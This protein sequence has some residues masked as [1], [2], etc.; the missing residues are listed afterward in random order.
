MSSDRCKLDIVVERYDLDEFE[1]LYD[2]VD[3]RLLSRWTGED[4]KSS[5]GYRALTEWFNKRLLKTVYDE[6]GRDTTGTRVESDYAVLT[7]DKELL[8]E[9]VKDELRASGINPEQV[10][11]DMISWSTMRRHLNSCLDGEKQVGGA[12]S[13][14][15]QRSVD[16]ASKVAES[17][18]KEALSSL[19]SAG[20][21]PAGSR[22]NVG[23]Q[24]L[25]GC[26][27]CQTR[28]PFEDAVERGYVCKDHFPVAMTAEGDD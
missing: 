1:T 19:D 24:I 25:L 14:W 23:V 5:D 20:T 9:E 21:L 2:S 28:I 7:G 12:D 22:A 15:E 16:I 4:G 26:P 10:Q 27:D 11:R 6:H 17:K 13:D 3:D 8:R 18:V